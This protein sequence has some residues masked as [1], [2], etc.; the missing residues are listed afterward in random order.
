MPNNAGLVSMGAFYGESIRLYTLFLPLSLMVDQFTQEERSKLMSKIRSKNTTFEGG[1]FK[2]LRKAK[3]NYRRHPKNVYG[4]PDAA[5]KSKRIAIFFDSDFWH[6]FNWKKSK[7][8]FISRKKFWIG[9]IEKNMNRDIEVTQELK[10]S[11]WTVLRLWEHEI[12]KN[13][14][15]CIVRIKRVYAK[16]ETK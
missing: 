12:R 15:R 3:V 16:T 6:G 9:K 1:G 2:L 10:R 14:N 7:H 13:P 4:N 11:D 5:N 8:D